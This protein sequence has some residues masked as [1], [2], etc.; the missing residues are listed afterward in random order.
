MENNGG[1]GKTEDNLVNKVKSMKQGMYIANFNMNSCRTGAGNL[2][3]AGAGNLWLGAASNFEANTVKN[4]RK[5][6][7]EIGLFYY[8][9]K[10]WQVGAWSQKWCRTLHSILLVTITAQKKSRLLPLRYS[11]NWTF[12]LLE[13]HL[14]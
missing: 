10:K 7:L 6:N 14:G 3:H 4:N 1:T 2:R 5:D 13:I 9:I 11:N 12:E 8:N